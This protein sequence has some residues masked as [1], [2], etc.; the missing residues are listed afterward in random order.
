MYCGYEGE[1]S[2]EASGRVQ[3]ELRGEMGRKQEGELST[4]EPRGEPRNHVTRM[5]EVAQDLRF[6]VGTGEEEL[7]TAPY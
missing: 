2:Q 7:G 4:W 3:T 5:T 6:R 1:C